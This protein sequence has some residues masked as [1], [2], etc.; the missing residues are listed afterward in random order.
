MTTLVVCRSSVHASRVREAF[1]LDADYISY[2]DALMGQRYDRIILFAP[3]HT[4][5]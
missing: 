3:P 4:L 5:S 1:G 2:G